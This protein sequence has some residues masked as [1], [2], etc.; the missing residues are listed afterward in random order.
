MP[1]AETYLATNVLPNLHTDGTF[2]LPEAPAG[3]HPRI[4]SAQAIELAK[5]AVRRI[6]PFLRPRL[7]EQH[8][9]PIVFEALT[10]DSRAFFA[11]SPYVDVPADVHLGLRNLHGP[12][13]LIYFRTV[14]GEP[15]LSVAVAAHT[16]ASYRNG[17][18]VTGFEDGNDFILQGIPSGKGEIAPVLP[19][20]AVEIVGSALGAKIVAVPELIAPDRGYAPQFARWRISMDRPIVVR[21]KETGEQRAVR[22]LFVGLGGRMEAPK[23]EQPATIQLEKIGRVPEEGIARRPDTPVVFEE[24]EPLPR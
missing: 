12:Y 2:R 11:G 21:G 17:H 5:G 19:E 7:E 15:V 16:Q 13:Y 18:I 14:S 10:A 3:A 1:E 23:G 24:V 8:G 9:G 4:S 22:E 6:A 20:R